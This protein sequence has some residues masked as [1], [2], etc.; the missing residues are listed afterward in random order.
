MDLEEA[1]KGMLDARKNLRSQQGINDP[2]YMST[3]MDRLAQYT[4]AV[5]EHLADL[6]KEYEEQ[7]TTLYMKLSK[8][9]SATQAENESKAQV[10]TLSA[11]MKRLTRLVNSSWK[12]VG[13]KQS[14]INHLE[15]SL[16]SGIGSGS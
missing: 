7:R 4:G 11:D 8:E 9:V 1:I 16:A 5:E 3:Q 12:I 6:E 10:G 13:E 15:R 2:N 14:R